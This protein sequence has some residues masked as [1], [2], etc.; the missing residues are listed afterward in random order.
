RRVLEHKAG[1]AHHARGATDGLS[2]CERPRK[3]SHQLRC[4]RHHEDQNLAGM[5][6][7]VQR[8]LHQQSPPEPERERLA[9]LNRIALDVWQRNLLKPC[10]SH[11]A[12]SSASAW[13]QTMGGLL[14]WIIVGLIAGFLAGKVMKGGGY[15]VLIDIILGMLGAIVGGWLF[16]LLGISAG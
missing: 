9:A 13:R 8:P 2:K 6:G 7:D 1:L 14:Y 16:G 12:A 3:L 11:A 4:R 10:A 15:G 5:A